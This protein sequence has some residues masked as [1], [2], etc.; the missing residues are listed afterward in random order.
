MND[1]QQLKTWIQQVDE[2]DLRLAIHALGDRGIDTVIDIFKSV[3][4]E[5]IAA[6]R[7]RI[8]HF[9]HP[10]KDAINELAQHNIIASMQPYHAIDDGR[11]AQSKLGAQR[12]KTAYAFRTILAAG[13]PLSFGSDWPVAPLSPMLGVYA[14]VTRRTDDRHRDGWQPQEKISV[15]QALHAYTYGNAYADFEETIS[16]TIELGKRADFVVLDAD[17]RAVATDKIKDITVLSTYINGRRLYS[18]KQSES[19]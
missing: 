13:A 15:E 7:F 18:A 16:G 6:R 8:E 9:Q 5:D 2:A 12:I 3:A 14:A 17:P 4:G 10:T 1:P 19:Q 11:W